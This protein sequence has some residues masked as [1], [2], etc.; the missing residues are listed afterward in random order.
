M[1]KLEFKY[2]DSVIPLV[3]AKDWGFDGA[4]NIPYKI[5]GIDP[6]GLG[7]LL[8]KNGAGWVRFSDVIP[9]SSLVKELL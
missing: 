1:P 5:I 6:N 4:V 2:G 7:Q 3:G 8:L 9:A